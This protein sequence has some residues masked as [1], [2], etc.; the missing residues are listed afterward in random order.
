MKS[1]FNENK[2]QILIY[3]TVTII[4]VTVYFLFLRFSEIMKEINSVLSI[5]TPFL[6]GFIIAYLLNPIIIFIEKK[7]LKPMK[8]EKP[9]RAV[10]ITITYLIFLATVTALIIPLAPQISRS[11]M[12]LLES[13]PVYII[14]FKQYLIQMS[15]LYNI[16]PEYVNDAFSISTL[17]QYTATIFQTSLG[18]MQ[19]IPKTITESVTNIVVGL[20]ISIYFLFGKE[21]FTRQICIVVKAMFKKETSENIFGLSRVTHNMFSKFIL[22]KVIDSLIIGLIAFPFMLVIYRPYALLTS[23]IIGFTNVIPFFGPIIGAV[24]CGIIILIV[25]PERIIWFLIFNIA[26]QQFDGNI[27]GPKILGDSTGLPPIWVMLGILA[28]GHFL[29]VAGMLIGVPVT[30]IVYLLIKAYLAE[31]LK[32]REEEN[33]DTTE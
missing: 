3:G 18:W 4:G 16:N 23:F 11:A 5:L 20:I 13:I 1:F 7:L 12:I 24:L 28:G 8:K 22:G 26:L 27:L 19:D 6:I 9:K 31:K 15:E 10:S 17:S 29:G 32:R 14:D 30:G 33:A 2:R 25:A 21:K